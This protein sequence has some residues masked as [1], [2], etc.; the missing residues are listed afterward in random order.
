MQLGTKY[1]LAVAEANIFFQPFNIFKQ[2]YLLLKVDEI[3]QRLFKSI[4]HG[5][6]PTL[7]DWNHG[8]QIGRFFAYGAIVYSGFFDN[9][10]SSLPR[11]LTYFLK[12]KVMS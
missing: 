12:L 1:T 9:C 11:F 8:D 3:P 5:M 6:R 10:R 7:N 2:K 4:V